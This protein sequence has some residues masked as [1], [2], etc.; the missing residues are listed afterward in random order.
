MGASVLEQYKGDII[1]AAAQDAPAWLAEIRRAGAEQFGALELPH[2]RM[3]EWRQTNIATV[4]ETAHTVPADSAPAPPSAASVAPFL[5]GNGAWTELVFVDGDYA[6]DLSVRPELP[7]GAVAGGL[8]E[9][10]RNGNADT[11]RRH[12]GSCLGARSAYTALNTALLRDGA[13]LHVPRGVALDAPVHF[14]FLSTRNGAPSAAHIRS[15]VVLEPT[16]AASVVCSFVS[17]SG[18]DAYLNN[19]VEEVVLSEGASLTRCEVVDEAPGGRRLSTLEVRQERDS[20]YEGYSVTLGGGI[21][22][23]Q[24]CVLLAG[25]GAETSLNGLYLNDGS[26]LLDNNLHV[27]HDA[28]HCT[29]RIAYKGVLDGE[30]RAVFTGKVH[31][32][33]HAQKTDSVQL[34]N[35]LVLSPAARV[36]T[37]PQLEIY[38]DDVKCTHGSTVGPPPGEIVFYFRSRGLD[39]KTA[40]AMLT[41]GFAG[42]V[43]KRLPVPT[44]RNRLDRAVFRRFSPENNG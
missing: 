24:A 37:K 15:L 30:S 20:R 34:N 13:F 5:M 28:E 43:V 1:R 8:W 12:L 42:D 18:A 11:V 31:V 41:C 17:L 7:G 26:R 39:E 29:S 38:A 3:E 25:E 40:R 32:A 6:P 22:R 21:V 10:A 33:S 9:A 36:D 23:N 44:L 19:V 14:V 35:N 4:N 27:M 2:T 16:A